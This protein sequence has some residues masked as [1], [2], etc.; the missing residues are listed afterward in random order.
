MTR[1]EE[2]YELCDLVFVSTGEPGGRPRLI[3]AMR[4]NAQATAAML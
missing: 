4:L 2:G 3:A 1:A